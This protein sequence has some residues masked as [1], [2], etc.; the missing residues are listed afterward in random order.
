MR[1]FI[2]I[3]FDEEII[4]ALT[5]LQKELKSSGISGRFT[6]PENLHLTLAFVGDYDRP[7]DILDVM[8][9]IP[10]SP[11]SLK[12][13]KLRF[14][15]DMLFAEIEECK[16]L[17]DYVRR[18]RRGL[19]DQG[20]PFDRKKFLAHITLIRKASIRE[21]S[22]RLPVRLPDKRIEVDRI[23]LMRSDRGRHGMIYTEIKP[24]V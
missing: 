13:D 2:S 12:I 6:R 18:L 11:F 24:T 20:I 7:E 1:L 23:S 22:F 14:F 15:R 17:K 3:N 16:E 21:D 4:E 9:T 5:G 19:S 10:C 8:E